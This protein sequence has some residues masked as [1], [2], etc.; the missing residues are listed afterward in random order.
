M[1]LHGEVEQWNIDVDVV[2]YFW[3]LIVYL[4]SHFGVLFEGYFSTSVMNNLLYN[5]F[6]FKLSS[7][8]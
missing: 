8:E 1:S 5:L 2:V 3:C 7:K 4:V 6:L